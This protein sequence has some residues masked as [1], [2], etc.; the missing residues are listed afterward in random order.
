MLLKQCL[1][2]E[3]D[4]VLTRQI[5]AQKLKLARKKEKVIVFLEILHASK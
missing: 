4:E 3:E 1:Q 2:R 5:F